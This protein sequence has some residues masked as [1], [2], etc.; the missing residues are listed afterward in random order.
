M[1]GWSV[2]P[3]RLFVPVPVLTEVD[4]LALLGERRELVPDGGR[5]ELRQTTSRMEREGATRRSDRSGRSDT[6]SRGGGGR[7]RATVEAAGGGGGRCGASVRAD[8]RRGELGPMGKC[9]R[10]HSLPERGD[11]TRGTQAGRGGTAATVRAAANHLARPP[12]QSARAAPAVLVAHGERGTRNQ[13]RHE[14]NRINTDQPRPASCGG[15]PG[16]PTEG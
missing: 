12:C 1:A 5:G 14:K 6:R 10:Q 3:L 15:L 13:R 11:A 16:A 8:R 7:H 9:A 2:G 4:R